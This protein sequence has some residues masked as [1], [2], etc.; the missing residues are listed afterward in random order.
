MRKFFYGFYI[1][2]NIDHFKIK[3]QYIN[4]SPCYDRKHIEPTVKYLSQIFE[5]NTSR[6]LF[7][8]VASFST[9]LVSIYIIYVV[10]IYFIVICR[11]FSLPMANRIQRN[12]LDLFNIL[13]ISLISLKIFITD[14]LIL[15][16]D[17][18]RKQ[19]ADL[20]EVVAFFIT[21][22]VIKCTCMYISNQLYGYSYTF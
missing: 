2:Y 20:F 1:S 19:F 16:P 7:V 12:Q 14:H 10:K 21:Y 17:L 9:H 22:L 18:L 13:N 3:P 11:V 15:K 8:I 6:G 4:Y 5:E